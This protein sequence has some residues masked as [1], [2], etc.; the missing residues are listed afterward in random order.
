MTL[1]ESISQVFD[2]EIQSVLD[3]CIKRYGELF[4]EHEINRFSI[5]KDRDR[6][7]HI[8]NII[9]MLQGFKNKTKA[10]GT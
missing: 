2:M 3:A 9:R 10:D 8:D 7:K 6:N 5:P 4:P 1:E